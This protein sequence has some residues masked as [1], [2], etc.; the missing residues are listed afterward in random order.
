MTKGRSRKEYFQ[1][2]GGLTGTLDY[3]KRTSS[4]LVID[5][6][7]GTTRGVSEI[8]QSDEGQG[9][10]FRATVMQDDTNIANYLGTDKTILTSVEKLEGIADQSVGL[11][12][13]L[14]SIAYS[15]EPKKAVESIDRVLIPGG[16][17]KATFQDPEREHALVPMKP[18][19]DIE[20]ALLAKGYDTA[21][22]KNPDQNT[23]VYI[24]LALK[25][26]ATV[27]AEELLHADIQS[28]PKEDKDQVLAERMIRRG[29][30]LG[31]DLLGP[32]PDPTAED[33]N[34]AIG[35]L[36]NEFGYDDDDAVKIQQLL[37]ERYLSTSSTNSVDEL[38][39]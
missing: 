6:G 1:F 19:D 10:D 5:I 32:I 11:A 34:G 38:S 15:T 30:G 21:K 12:I 7:A 9:L 37:L 23:A 26:G 27:T 17:L 36:K 39:E 3:V 25:K 29:Y 18:A 2:L 8:A 13:G 22:I 16:V 4:N 35:R 31:L 14:N 24:L 20:A 28:L 33:I